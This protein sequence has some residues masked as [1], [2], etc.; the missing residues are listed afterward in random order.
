MPYVVD[1][2]DIYDY[3]VLA[4]I[5]LQSPSRQSPSPH[6]LKRPRHPITRVNA[7]ILAAG[8][9]RRLWPYTSERPKCLL[10]LGTQTILEHQL[11]RLA[12][13]GVTRVTVVAGFG[14]EAVRSEACRVRIP[15]LAVQV[16]FNPFYAAADNLISLWAARAEMGGDFLVLNGDNVFH[17]GVP[18]L[19]LDNHPATCRLLVRRQPQY[20]PEDMKVTLADGRLR[21]IGKDLLPA[22]THATS[23]GFMRFRD[24]GAVALQHVLEAAV[25]AEGALSSYYL[26]CV[27]RLADVGVEVVCQDVGHLACVDIDTPQDLHAVR[28]GQ[29]QF[30]EARI[31]PT[32]AMAVRLV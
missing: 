18:E 23:L 19:L 29:A 28:A 22:S 6:D 11:V 15:G 21:R 14:L 7:L 26:D 10:D 8:R 16:V 3:L 27:Q 1:H 31:E 17:P 25:R 2:T 20:G 30:S 4:G 13:A 32:A 9:G 12:A 24:D 5:R